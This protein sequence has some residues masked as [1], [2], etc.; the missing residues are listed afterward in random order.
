MGAAAISS[1]VGLGGC[2]APSG[3]T[4][5][6]WSLRMAFVG[7]GI[8][9]LMRAQRGFNSLREG[10]GELVFCQQMN[11]VHAGFFLGASPI[12]INL[13]VR[14]MA[15]DT[16]GANPGEARMTDKV[17]RRVTRRRVIAGTAMALGGLAISGGRGAAQEKTARAG[18]IIT[19]KAIHQEKDLHAS[20]QRLYEILLDSKQFTA[21]SGGRAAEIHGEVGGTFSVFAGH[22][23]G[24]NLELVPNQRIV[25]AWR[26]VTWP[27]GI[28]SIAR[29][30]LVA[31]TPA[32]QSSATRIIFDHTGFPSELAEHL[33]SGWRENY[34]NALR[35]YLT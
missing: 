24:R 4:A 22:I 10:W 12:T 1:A 30:E 8:S 19:V 29:F 11:F 16:I 21:F 18:T 35:K 27:E 33:E 5:R 17:N 23:V 26:V 32:G 9:A 15:R 13:P 31:Q 7:N 14:R 6:S 34:W 20:R 2:N 28:Y 3:W 25:Q